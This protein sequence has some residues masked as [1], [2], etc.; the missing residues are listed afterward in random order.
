MAKRKE[1]PDTDDSVLVEAAKQ[2]G[3][4]VG[5]VA[6]ATGLAGSSDQAGTA[7]AKPEK[8]QKKN[9]QRLPRRE[10]K[11]RQKVTASQQ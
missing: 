11:A 8:L 1:Q 9:K 10:K 6:A 2:I 4:T 5:R 7:K 3:A